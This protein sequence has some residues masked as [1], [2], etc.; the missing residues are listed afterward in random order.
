MPMASFFFE[1]LLIFYPHHRLAAS[2]CRATTGDTQHLDQQQHSQLSTFRG[3]PL[4]CA[5]L[6]AI[7]VFFCQAASTSILLIKQSQLTQHQHWFYPPSSFRMKKIYHP[8]SESWRMPTTKVPVRC[9]WKFLIA[10]PHGSITTT[11]Q[12]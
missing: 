5:L 8:S 2:R 6:S 12:K 10:V 7:L 9:K 3:S 1:P 4:I 11:S